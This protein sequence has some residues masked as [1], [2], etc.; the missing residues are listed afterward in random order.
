MGELGR[1]HLH[2]HTAPQGGLRREE[3]PGHAPAAEL[4]LDGVAAG[5]GSREP[6]NGLRQ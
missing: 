3:D 1:Q 4:A 5:Q 6:F 2:H